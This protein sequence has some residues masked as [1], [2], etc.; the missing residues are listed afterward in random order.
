MKV[1]NS[2]SRKLSSAVYNLIESRGEVTEATA[3][4]MYPIKWQIKAGY[5]HSHKHV[6]VHLI[7][8]KSLHIVK[9]SSVHAP[10]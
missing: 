5:E 1:I 6:N 4:S 7:G 10:V 2:R 8:I 9:H 3:V